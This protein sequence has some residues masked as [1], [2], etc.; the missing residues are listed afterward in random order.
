MIIPTSGVFDAS[1][2]ATFPWE[3]DGVFLSEAIVLM[4]Y[5]FL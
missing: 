1:V 4:I 5:R 2:F 3:R